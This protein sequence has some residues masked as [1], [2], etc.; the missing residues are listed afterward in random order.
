MNTCSRISVITIYFRKIITYI[1]SYTRSKHY[2][3]PSHFAIIIFFQVI[4]FSRDR[5]EVNGGFI[6]LLTETRA[7]YAAVADILLY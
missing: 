3:L 1:S 4:V 6:A 5:Y 7:I 2:N